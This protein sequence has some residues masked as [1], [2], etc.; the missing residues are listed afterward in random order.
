MSDFTIYGIALKQWLIALGLVAGFFLLGYALERL[1]ISRLRRWALQTSWKLDDVLINSLSG[2]IIPLFLL[3]G[4]RLSLTQLPLT[5]ELTDGT[6][7]ALILVAILLVTVFVA[8]LTLAAIA[9]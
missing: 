9:R 7:K 1:V 6:N 4:L 3:G 5:A 8:R 2:M